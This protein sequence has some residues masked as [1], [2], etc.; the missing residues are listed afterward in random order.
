MQ[1]VRATVPFR[2]IL[3]AAAA[4][5]AGGCSIDRLQLP[6]DYPGPKPL[7]RELAA[8]FEYERA[9]IDPEIE[10]IE[11]TATYERFRGA[12]RA[13]CPVTN[14][15]RRVVFEMWRSKVGEGPRPCIVVV[16]ILAGRYPECRHLGALFSANGMHAFFVHREE[17][18]LAPENR[19]SD[20]ETIVRRAVVNVRR[21][22]DWVAARPE[23]DPA[24]IGLCG[25]SMGAI[26]GAIVAAVEPRIR[27]SVLIMGGGDL[28]GIVWRSRERPVLCWKRAL[29]RRLDL[30]GEEEFAAAFRAGFVSD[31]LL[32][33]P[34]VDARTVLQFIARYDDRVPTENQWRL[35]EALGRP[36]G[37]SIPCGH[38]TAIFWVG[39]AEEQ[40]LAFYRE[41]FAGGG[42]GVPGRPALATPVPPADPAAR[43]A[44]G[45]P[46]RA[47]DRQ[48][49]AA[50][51]RPGARRQ[52]ALIGAPRE[53]A[54]SAAPHEPAPDAALRPAAP[55]LPP[56]QR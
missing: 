35:W 21:T 31:P 56:G 12:Y 33:A 23:V 39:F 16:P 24:R 9:P 49:A 34:H 10:T 28:A 27:R 19:P 8:R 15:E 17:D 1:N 32:F 20:L 44:P 26:G 54:S 30:E 4:L 38:Y 25:I 18:M 6:A 22:L 55:A 48:R 46:L 52:P 37:F 3:A 5:V 42:G 50:A 53:P 41:G 47:R 13:P 36:S 2:A 45:A 43:A 51:R 7:P 40:A 29:A 11:E 14:E